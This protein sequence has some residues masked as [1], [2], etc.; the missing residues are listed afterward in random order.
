MKERQ[1]RF[2]LFINVWAAQ[3]DSLDVYLG[4]YLD[5]DFG[6]CFIETPVC[7]GVCDFTNNSETEEQ[8]GIILLPLG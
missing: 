6:K 7:S 5:F 8:G 3:K 1:F 4:Q 2:F